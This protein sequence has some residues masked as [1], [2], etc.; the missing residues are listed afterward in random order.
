MQTL[1]LIA[2]CSPS[3]VPPRGSATHTRLAASR[4]R[5]R[6][7]NVFSEVA[8][9]GTAGSTTWVAG[10]ANERDAFTPLDVPQFAY[11]YNVP[12][13]FAQADVQVASWL[14]V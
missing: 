2:T 3:A 14:A 4:E 12:G 9:R 8:V 1:W 6:H 10:V 5:D 7:S 13:V 11:T